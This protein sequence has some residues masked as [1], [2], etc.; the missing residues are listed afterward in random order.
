MIEQRQVTVRGYFE[1]TPDVLHTATGLA[2]VETGVTMIS[3]TVQYDGAMIVGPG[4]VLAFDPDVDSTLELAGNLIVR[5]GGGL[6]M[7]PSSAAVTHRLRW[8]V[9]DESRYVGGGMEPLDTDVGLWAVGRCSLDVRGTPKTE[10]RRAVGSVGIGAT[11][12]QLDGDVVGWLPGDDLAVAPTAPV[13]TANW[14]DLY[15]YPK[16]ASVEGRLVHLDRPIGRGHPAVATRTGRLLGAEVLN[17]TRNVI[18]E[19][20]P[21]GRAHVAVVPEVL[22]DGS[23]SHDDGPVSMSH[24][25]V[26]HMGPRQPTGE[27]NFT[28]GV[29]GRYP[30]HFHHRGDGSRGTVIEGAVVRDSGSHGFVPHLSHGIRHVRCIAHNTIDDPMWWDPRQP[31]QQVQDPSNGTEWVGCVVS[32]VTVIPNFRGSR[33]GGFNLGEGVGNVCRGTVAVG[34]QGNVQASGHLW[35]EGA[36]AVWDF[37]DNVE[38][39][40]KRDGIF[41]WQNTG[42]EHMVVGTVAYNNGN[43]GVEHGAYGN[44][45]KYRDGEVYGSGRAPLLIHSH[46]SGPYVPGS[47]VGLQVWERYLLDA[48]GMPH[49]VEITKHTGLGDG[50]TVLRDCV[51]RNHGWAA[52]GFTY[53]RNNGPTSRE[54]LHIVDCEKDPAKPWVAWLIDPMPGSEILVIVGGTVVEEWRF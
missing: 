54:W 5:P 14:Y 39:N 42:N 2:T 13:T 23:H 30:L 31:G 44:P 4:E 3:G 40:C 10:W 36:F 33:L 1:Q 35:P 28:A 22:P 47:D 16:V 50:P 26:R 12:I 52:V 15:D 20:T 37:A 27:Q 21:T 11:A 17:L 9:V 29:L 32:R 34:V 45:Y 41:T 49:A 46:S 48:D 19:G 18:I 43:C 6:R 38:H 51:F 7:L 8:P 24:F 53:T 25:V